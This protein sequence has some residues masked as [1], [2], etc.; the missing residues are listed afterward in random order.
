MDDE[1]IYVPY[2]WIGCAGWLIERPTL[3][4][5]ALGSVPSQRNNWFQFNIEPPTP[6]PKLRPGTN[7]SV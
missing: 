3:R 1:L 6:E 7:G 2:S 5:W 4:V